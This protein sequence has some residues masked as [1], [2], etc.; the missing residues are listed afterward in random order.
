L[1]QPRFI[2]HQGWQFIITLDESSFCLS[3]DREQIWLR[4]EEQA[5]ER[6][7]HIIQDPKMM[8]TMAWNP[9]DFIYSPQF[10]KA[11]H[12][13]PSTTV[14][15]FAQSFFRFARNLMGANSLLMLTMQDPMPPEN[16]ELF[17]K[18]IGS[19]SPYT[20]RTHLIS[21]HPTSFSSNISNIVCRESLF[22]HMKNYLQQFM[23]SSGHPATNLGRR[24]PALDEETRMGFSEQW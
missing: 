1:C 14:L 24:N 6:P 21:H 9:L 7:R 22:H 3:T 13:T 20:R 19:A 15:I 8:V 10:Q 16:S 5:S 12:L 17:A 18:K 23:K 2:G 4:V 11:T